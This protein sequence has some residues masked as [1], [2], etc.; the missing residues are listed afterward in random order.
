[1]K[2]KAT[3]TDRG[4]RTLEKGICPALERHGKACHMLL[5]REDVHLIQT[6]LDADGM[7]IC[8]RWAIDIL[9]E[10]NTYTCDSR[11]HN[12]IAFQLEVG[13]LRRVLQAAGAHD[14][15]SL[16]VKLAMRA[17][18]TGANTAPVSKP[19]LTFTC[20]GPNLNMVQDLP[21][22]KPH[23][24]A[25]IDRLVMDKD[26]TQVCPFYLDLQGEGQ[27]IQAIVDKLRSIS[28]TMTLLTTKHGHLH[29]QVTAEQVQ[30]ATE[31]QSLEVL[32]AAVAKGA[33]P[34]TE[35][36]PEGR[37]QEAT[38]NGDAASAIV[39]VKHF[40]KSLHSSQLT[41]P[42][43]VLCGIGDTG[44]HVHFMFVYRDPFSEAG[45]DDKISLSYKLPV[46]QENDL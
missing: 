41:Q 13:L 15:D 32:P 21:I 22:S 38:R 11:H 28:A 29:L 7:L 20:R 42:A 31:V 39:Q 17:V 8:A 35:A 1:M 46:L 34:L 30:L 44:G 16:E 36:A 4:L 9:F 33:Q 23:L 43:Q 10:P 37:L 19:F 40:T 5:S 12:L 3:F 26:I 14:A 25:E 27:R 18:P 45:Y 6:T 24:P 2:F